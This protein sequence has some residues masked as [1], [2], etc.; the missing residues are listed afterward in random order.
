MLLH[1]S[2]ADYE[3]ASTVGTE[4]PVPRRQN[5]QVVA[6]WSP[7]G[8]LPLPQRGQNLNLRCSS[9]CP[10]QQVRGRGSTRNR[11]WDVGTVRVLMV[12]MVLSS[13]LCRGLAL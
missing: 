13:F 1:R 10:H 2:R 5:H 12:F 11:A 7:A 6:R 8:R 4:G 3:M 9:S